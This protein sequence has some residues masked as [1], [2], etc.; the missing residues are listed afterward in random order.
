MKIYR[1]YACVDVEVEADSE[2]EA[3]RL[4][5]EGYTDEVRNVIDIEEVE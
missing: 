5:E 4:F 3:L 1:I 2:Q